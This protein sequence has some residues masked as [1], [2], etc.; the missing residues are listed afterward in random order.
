MS[1]IAIIIGPLY[2]S[3]FREWRLKAHLQFQEL[4]LNIFIRHEPP[5]NSFIFPLQG[6]LHS[7]E[8]AGNTIVSSFPHL[9]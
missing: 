6:I 2:I 1:D 7:N 4:V 8:F 5:Q 9:H 3:F